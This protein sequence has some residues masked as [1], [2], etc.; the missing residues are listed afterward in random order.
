[1]DL[2]YNTLGK[3]AIKSIRGL[4]N[5]ITLKLVFCNIGDEG[6]RDFANGN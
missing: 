6:L 2:S 4:K 1:M 5:L 3:K